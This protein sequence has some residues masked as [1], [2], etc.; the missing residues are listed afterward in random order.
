[1]RMV[2]SCFQRALLFV[3][4]VDSEGLGPGSGPNMIPYVPTLGLE[5]AWGVSEY[6]SLCAHYA[7][8]VSTICIYLLTNFEL[9]DQFPYI[10]VLLHYLANMS[11]MSLTINIH[12]ILARCLPILHLLSRSLSLLAHYST[13]GR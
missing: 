13:P 9:L 2:C 4:A 1:M 6:C 7:I 3:S 12:Q 11:S 10:C 8:Y 5:G